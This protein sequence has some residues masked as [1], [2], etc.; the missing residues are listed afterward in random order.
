MNLDDA[1]SEPFA[2][3]VSFHIQFNRQIKFSFGALAM[4][5]ATADA[6]IRN[7]D[8]PFKLPTGNEPWGPATTWRDLDPLIS[9]AEAF[10]SEIGIVRAASAFDDYITRATAEL[11]RFKG[12][13]APIDAE[14]KISRAIA[15]LKADPSQFSDELE[16]VEFF[17]CA[18]NCIV[19]RSGRASNQLSER[20]KS[21]SLRSVIERWPKRK[22][23]WKLALP[24]ISVGRP[25]S[26][27]PRH[28]IMASDAYYRLGA[29]L[30]KQLVAALGPEGIVGMA[31]HWCLLADNPVPCRAKLNPHVMVRDQLTTRYRVREVDHTEIADAFH[32]LGKWEDVRRAYEALFPDGPRSKR[33]KRS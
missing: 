3:L 1:R 25:V 13:D 27:Q 14:G 31:A 5:Q 29:A 10:I 7:G 26:W 24:D 2:S 19:H 23:K 6:A 4:L 33:K 12:N 8:V 32:S 15:L 9:S 28:A 20:A 21:A 22:G 11:S 17:E 30:D 18:R 16:M